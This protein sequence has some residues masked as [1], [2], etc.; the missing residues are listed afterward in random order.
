[1]A[2][3]G[4]ERLDVVRNTGSEGPRQCKEHRFHPRALIAA[5]S[6]FAVRAERIGY[7]FDRSIRLTDYVAEV[8]VSGH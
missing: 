7:R 4:Q 5:K 6:G 8:D 1:M 3:Y 2:D